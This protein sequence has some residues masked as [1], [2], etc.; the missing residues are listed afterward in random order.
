[1]VVSQRT[2]WHLARLGRRPT[3][4]D[5]ASSR[6]LYYPPRGFELEV[7][8]SAWYR[9]H[10][11]GSPF[12]ANDWERFRDPR[13][14]TYTKYTELMKTREAFVDGVLA[15]SDPSRLSAEWR[16]TLDRVL[17]ALRYPVHGLQMLAA[18]VGHM[19]PSGRIVIACAFQAAD[20][21]RRIQRLAYRTRELGG[22]GAGFGR[23]PW[24]SEPM[25]QPMREAIERMLAIRDWGEAFVALALALKP[26]FD[27]LFV[28]QLG[29]LARR[30][31]DDTFGNVLFSLA[32]D[33]RWHAEWSAE[34]L[35]VALQDRPEN[36]Q[37]IRGWLDRWNPLAQSATSAFA[38]VF[39]PRTGAAE[40]AYTR[41]ASV[42]P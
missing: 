31:G 24:Q 33:C 32:E 38:P 13:E 36:A 9:A 34:L 15:A 41:A 10:Q 28:A 2:Y 30:A 17:P 20:E 29:E 40:A 35:R 14:T 23:E 6:L 18:Y 7:P 21:V 27:E 11:T 16:A 37:V 3:D 1:V 5:I 42:L 4:Y 25:W 19:A 26:R 22:A 12:V 8:L 39:G